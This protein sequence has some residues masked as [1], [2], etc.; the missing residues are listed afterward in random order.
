MTEVR[1]EVPSILVVDDDPE[2]CRFMAELLAHGDRQIE[3]AHEPGAALRRARE[4][5]FDLVI[6]DIHLNAELSGIDIL[7][8]FKEAD[9]GVEVILISGFGTL[10]TAL[11]AVR[12]GAFDY[13]SKPFDIGQVKSA[14]ERALRQRARG[15]SQPA[16][17]ATPAG[18]IG[19]DELI[20]RSGAMLTVYKLIAQATG[21]LAPVLITGE[22]GTGKELVARAIHR[23]GARR[24]RPF[25]AVNCGALAEGLLESELF[26]H[27]RGSFTGAVSDKRGLFEEADGGTIFLDEIG[28]TPP[29]LQVRLLRVIEQGELR[30]VGGTHEK[31]VDARVIAAT[32]RDLERAVAEGAFRQDLY[33]RLNVFR[34]AIPP[35]RERPEDIPLLAAHFLRRSNERLGRPAWLTAAAENALQAH[36]WTGNI[37]ELQNVLERVV[38]A[39]GGPIDRDDLPAS[40][41]GATASFEASLFVDLPS[42][43]AIEKRYLKHVLA[44]MGGNRSRA[45]EVLGIDR[46]TLYRMAERFGIDLSGDDA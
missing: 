2:T 14:V 17:P 11:E 8:R 30:P 43:E 35:L 9:P 26:G 44:E 46:R 39:H 4:G 15:A 41:L 29:A 1:A 34:I 24:A 42:L 38:L 6:S 12:A 3:L 19:R 21:S 37:R 27:V 22:T 16:P 23:H 18:A 32:H 10:E 31:R 13:V 36:P 7:R 28:E 20:G 5:R 45:A 33:Y 25:V 40:L